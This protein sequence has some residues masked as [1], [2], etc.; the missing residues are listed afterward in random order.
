[1][2]EAGLTADV[3]ALR[4]KDEINGLAEKTSTFDK[5]RVD[6]NRE[7]I[8]SAE[9]PDIVVPG[10]GISVQTLAAQISNFLGIKNRHKITGEFVT[11][12]GQIFVNLRLDERPFFSEGL[13]EGRMDDLLMTAARASLRIT[14]PYS[15]GL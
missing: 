14:Q 7:I 1:M 13:A 8:P 9:L 6:K 4:L 15:F 5:N 11:R 2:T 3:A 10:V 12:A